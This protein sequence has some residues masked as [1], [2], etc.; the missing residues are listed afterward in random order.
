MHPGVPRG[1]RSSSQF[2]RPQISSITSV[3]ADRIPLLYLTYMGIQREYSSN[4]TGVY[5][6]IV[7][8]IAMPGTAFKAKNALITGVRKAPFGVEILKGLLS[9]SAHVVVT[10]SR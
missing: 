9:G 8:E 7:H 6:D 5:F 4:P 10:T 2:L 1:R 3:S